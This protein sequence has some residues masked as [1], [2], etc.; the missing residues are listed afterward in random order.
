MLFIDKERNIYR[1][2]NIVGNDQE[3]RFGGIVMIPPAFK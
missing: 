3:D 2:N 1:H